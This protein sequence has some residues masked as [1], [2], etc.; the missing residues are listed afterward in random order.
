MLTRVDNAQPDSPIV[1]GLAIDLLVWQEP[2]QTTGA[3]Q[4]WQSTMTGFI[5]SP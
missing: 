1:S 5:Q 3:G 2:D 4:M